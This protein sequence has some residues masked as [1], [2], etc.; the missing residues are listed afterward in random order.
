MISLLRASHPSD[1]A[2]LQVGCFIY[3]A[4]QVY[5]VMAWNKDGALSIR[6]ENTQTREME[7]W[8]IKE[9]FSSEQEIL[10][11]STVEELQSKV[12]H[13]APL[14]GPS[15]SV[16]VPEALLKKADHLIGVVQ[17]IEDEIARRKADALLKGEKFSRTQAIKSAC[18]ALK[19]AYTRY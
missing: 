7:D 3:R 8:R 14:P 16:Q 4:S 15:S 1:Q 9:L 11:A 19:I 5:R 13:P 12:A 18:D 6:V 17:Q 10:I 2:R